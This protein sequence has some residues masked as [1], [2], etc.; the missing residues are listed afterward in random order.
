[1]RGW[2]RT[3]GFIKKHL[4][5]ARK[6]VES[7]A[8]GFFLASQKHKEY[9]KAGETNVCDGEIWYCAVR[10]WCVNHLLQNCPRYSGVRNSLYRCFH[11]TRVGHCVWHVLVCSIPHVQD[12]LEMSSFGK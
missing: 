12:S 7:E 2:E 4:D 3:L 6:I 11:A 5:C 10:N 1:M 8:A 9:Q